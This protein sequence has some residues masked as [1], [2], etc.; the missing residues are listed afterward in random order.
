MELPDGKFACTLCKGKKTTKIASR[1]RMCPACGG[2]GLRVSELESEI[3]FQINQRQ[4]MQQERDTLR[5]WVKSNTNCS[6]CEGNQNKTYGG[7][8]CK[9]CG[10]EG[11]MPWGG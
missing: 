2:T 8:A 9:E 3:G 4:R 1:E 10:L 5:E 6:T 7:T 11:T